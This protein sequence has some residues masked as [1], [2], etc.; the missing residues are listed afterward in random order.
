MLTTRDLCKNME[1][2]EL[3]AARGVARGSQVWAWAVTSPAVLFV[4][5]YHYQRCLL[6][7]GASSRTK[8]CAGYRRSAAPFP[9]RS[10]HAVQSCQTTD[11]G[12]VTYLHFSSALLLPLKAPTS[13]EMGVYVLST[14]C[15]TEL[16]VQHILHLQLLCE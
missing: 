9:L 13:R 12:I 4:F 5:P 6:L 10:H 14:S 16:V 11:L 7:S 15:S 3:S 2:W 1:L 8:C